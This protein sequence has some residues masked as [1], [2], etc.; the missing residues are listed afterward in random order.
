METFS[1][2]D[3]QKIVTISD[4]HKRDE[5]LT[6]TIPVH[7]LANAYRYQSRKLYIN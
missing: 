3:V 5:W 4:D 1:T 7:W 6:L 2:H